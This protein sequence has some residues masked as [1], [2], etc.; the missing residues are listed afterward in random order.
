MHL[1]Y[2]LCKKN[3]YIPESPGRRALCSKSCHVGKKEE[4][5]K[6]TV[7][8]EL[9]IQF[10]ERSCNKDKN[11]IAWIFPFWIFANVTFE[12][13]WGSP[14]EIQVTLTVTDVNKSWEH[15][16]GHQKA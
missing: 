10:I 11:W 4:E 2:R 1:S 15:L 12:R 8:A 6:Q 13:Y 14:K 3:K 7:G 5:K 16:S 9:Q